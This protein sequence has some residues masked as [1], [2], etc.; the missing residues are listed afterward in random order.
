MESVPSSPVE[1]ETTS[2]EEMAS[3]LPGELSLPDGFSVSENFPEVAP[4]KV[5]E[6]TEKSTD[7]L[8]ENSIIAETVDSR[9]GETTVGVSLQ[10]TKL[11]DALKSGLSAGTSS[12]E[13]DH[14][15]NSSS[16]MT[17]TSSPEHEQGEKEMQVLSDFL[18]EST[19][20]EFATKSAEKLRR[21]PVPLSG[22]EATPVIETDAGSQRGPLL[23]GTD[24]SSKVNAGNE[25]SVEGNLV[26]SATDSDGDDSDR[27]S[28]SQTSHLP[29]ATLRRDPSTNDEPL[30]DMLEL[31]IAELE[32]ASTGSLK[33]DEEAAKRGTLN[34]TN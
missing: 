26:E 24:P 16:E 20:A 17:E 18:M 25:D 30:Q 10:E 33:I 3:H 29:M 23:F 14:I 7:T 34:I 6:N 4:S 1:V 13:T 8:F 28:S 22:G 12:P 27:P 31:K 2:V 9:S 21:F 32:V 11:A 19:V 15:L 5:S